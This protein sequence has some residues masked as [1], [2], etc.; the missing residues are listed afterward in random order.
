MTVPRFTSS[1]TAAFRRNGT[2]FPSPAVIARADRPVAIRNPCGALRRPAPL[3]PERCGLPWPDGPR[4]D[5]GGRWLVLLFCPVKYRDL[6]GGGNVARPTVRIPYAEREPATGREVLLDFHEPQS[7]RPELA[8]GT[9]GRPVGKFYSTFMKHDPPG[10]NWLPALP[11][12]KSPGSE[13][14][15]D[16]H[17]FVENRFRSRTTRVLL[18]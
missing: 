15:G 8:P 12:K 13:E 10:P 11:G 3:G 2:I 7:T 6:V 14:P 18:A 9:A 4:N 16:F 5:G 17:C 1:M